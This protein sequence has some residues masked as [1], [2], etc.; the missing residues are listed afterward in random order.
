MISGYPQPMRFQI[1]RGV[2]NRYDQMIRDDSDGTRPFWRTRNE[3]VSQKQSKPGRTAASFFLKGTTRQVMCLPPTPGGELLGRVRT[4]LEGYLGPDHGTTKFSERAGPAVTSGLAKDD[5]FPALGCAFDDPTCLVG[6]G[7]D[8][9]SQTYEIICE[10][11]C[12][13][14][15]AGE[16]IAAGAQR[17]GINA[18]APQRAQVIAGSRRR[19]LGQTGTS[20]HRRQINHKS[21]KTSVIKKHNHEIHSQDQQ[22]PTYQMKAL[23]G[24]RSVLNRLITEGVYIDGEEKDQPGSLMNSRGEAGCGKMVRYVPEVRRI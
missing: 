19:Y 21:G 1:L 7:C 16:N 23:R 3:I 22:P 12:Q 18:R 15:Q 5:P 24:S 10:Q 2:L 4:Q 9:V 17:H 13:P 6:A 8:K 14:N 20:L 11:C